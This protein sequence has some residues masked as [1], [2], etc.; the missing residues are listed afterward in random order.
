LKITFAFSNSILNI[1]N[2]VEE[3]LESELNTF[4]S[5]FGGTSGV[6]WES[7][8]ISLVFIQ[9]NIWEKVFLLSILDDVILDIKTGLVI[10]ECFL[11]L[12]TLLRSIWQVLS[13]SIVVCLLSI[14][15]LCL[16]C[17]EVELKSIFFSSS[18]NWESLS[19]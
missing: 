17:I 12:D 16:D 3:L 15:K 9:L 19:I 11:H 2:C 18:S 6:N 7:K 13:E 8:C 10:G 1:E 4:L 14:V 5:S